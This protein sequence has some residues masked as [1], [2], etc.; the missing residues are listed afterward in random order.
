MLARGL[1]TLL[2]VALLFAWTNALVH[3]VAHV[4]AAGSLVHLAD[5]HGDEDSPDPLCD[6]IA[7]LALSITGSSN[8][9]VAL[10]RVSEKPDVR[11]SGISSGSLLLAYRSQAPP[12]FS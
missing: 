5:G 4:D 6:A 2:A 10:P 3:P 11:T 12:Q 7:A 1:R 9:V 8:V